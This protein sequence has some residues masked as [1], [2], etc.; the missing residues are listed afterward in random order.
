MAKVQ[1]DD[2]GLREIAFNYELG[3]KSHSSLGDSGKS[4]HDSFDFSSSKWD[5]SFSFGDKGFDTW[6]RDRGHDRG[7]FFVFTWKDGGKDRD[8]RHDFGWQ[9]SGN[10]PSGPSESGLEP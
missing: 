10:W 3:H 5:D 8:D 4:S 7:E 6:G 1:A 2:F 9:H